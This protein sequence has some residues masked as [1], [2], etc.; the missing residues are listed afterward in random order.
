M[1][2]GE[3][4]KKYSVLARKLNNL[5]NMKGDRVQKLGKITGRSE[6][7]RK[8]IN[9]LNHNSVKISQDTEKS[10][11]KLRRLCV[12]LTYEKNNW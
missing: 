6:H 3:K 9:Y 10:P 12:T 7:Q 2:V 5:W 11:G 1:K 4:L 8:N